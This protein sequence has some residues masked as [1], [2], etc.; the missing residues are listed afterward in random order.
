MVVPRLEMVYPLL[1]AYA[2]FVYVGKHLEKADRIVQE[3]EVM[4]LD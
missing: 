1:F 3:V 2:L 4:K